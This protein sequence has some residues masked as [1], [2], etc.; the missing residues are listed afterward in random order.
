MLEFIKLLLSF[1]CGR[2]CEDVRSGGGGGRRR[3]AREGQKLA[4]RSASLARCACENHREGALNEPCDPTATIT[5]KTTTTDTT[6]T[7]L[8]QDNVHAN[9]RCLNSGAQTG[10]FEEALAGWPAD[11][12][13]ELRHLHA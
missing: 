13:D 2:D 7:H 6:Q 5:T 9:L 8:N 4:V 12:D 3:R 11:K 1:G 10:P